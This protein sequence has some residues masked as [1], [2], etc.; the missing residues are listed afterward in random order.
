MYRPFSNNKPTNCCQR[1]EVW[2]HWRQKWWPLNLQTELY[3]YC[4]FHAS[5]HLL[6]LISFILFH[7]SDHLLRPESARPA[8]LASWLQAAVWTSLPLFGWSQYVPEPFLTSCTVDW[9]GRSASNLSYV[10]MTIILCFVVHLVI[11][12]FCYV[13]ILV[14]SRRLTFGVRKNSNMIRL[15]EVLWHH[16]VETERNVTRVRASSS[17]ILIKPFSLI[18]QL[19]LMTVR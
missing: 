4:A 16:K 6:S 7:L 8:L 12:S 18:T 11:I 3:Y 17:M 10:A 9:G 1:T 13:R 15:E 5:S 2:L 14:I 19:P